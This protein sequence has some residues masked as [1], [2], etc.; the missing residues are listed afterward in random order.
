[1]VESVAGVDAE[2]GVQAVSPA[3]GA[4]RGGIHGELL[5]SGDGV[6][7]GVAPLAR[8][9]G[10]VGERI[11]MQACGR[12]IRIEAGVV[13][14]NAAR[15]AGAADRAREGRRQRESGAEIDLRGERPFAEERSG[16]TR[17]KEAQAGGCAGGVLCRE[18]DHVT[19]VE[20]R[21]RAFRT[22]VQPILRVERTNAPQSRVVDG[23]RV[24]VGDV[25]REAASQTTAKLDRPCLTRR[26]AVGC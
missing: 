1:M 24:G 22:Q 5:G 9:R 15:R 2:V 20:V 26:I 13:G 21:P 4:A 11:Q 23:L 19:L 14:A 17:R 18:A 16:L 3:K 6:A 8:A 7:A 10:G 25:R 12:V